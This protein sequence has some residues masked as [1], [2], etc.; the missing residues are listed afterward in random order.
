[1]T[2]KT[3]LKKEGEKEAL[4]H[5]HTLSRYSDWVEDILDHAPGFVLD[6]GCGDGVYTIELTKG[7]HEVVSADL[8]EV[9]LKRVKKYNGLVVACLATH[10]PFRKEVFDST[11]FVEVLEHLPTRREQ[12]LSLREIKRVLK[13]GGTLVLATPNK[14]IYGFVTK[15]WWRFGGQKP[16]PTH[17]T[18]LTFKE[19]IETVSKHFK[20]VYVRGKFGFLKN[21]TFQ[22]WLGHF[23]KICY[24]IL[25]VGKV[26]V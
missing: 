23:P 3:E 22:R 10:I 18:E 14:N 16:D 20:I 24:D 1:M 13:K 6:L 15:L 2:D 7:G 26:R 19:L 9:R 11:L 12:D 25:V 17:Y 21:P 8:S 5:P 4:V